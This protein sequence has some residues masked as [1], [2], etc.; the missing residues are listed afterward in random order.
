MLSAALPPQQ[1]YKDQRESIFGKKA[2]KV[3]SHSSTETGGRGGGHLI[4]S[5]CCPIQ[6]SLEL[7]S[8]INVMMHLVQNQI[9]SQ[10]PACDVLAVCSPAMRCRVTLLLSAAIFLLFFFS[11]FRI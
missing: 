1:L 10:L 6:P 5:E 3:V 2:Q 9:D 11:N 4:N 7:I 8:N